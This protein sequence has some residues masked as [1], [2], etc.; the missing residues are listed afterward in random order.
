M[1][2]KLWPK[3]CF[4]MKTW[5]W[6]GKLGKLCF[7]KIQNVFP[8]K[9]FGTF[10]DWAN[11]IIHRFQYCSIIWFRPGIQNSE[12][13]WSFQCW[14]SDWPCGYF[15]L[16]TFPLE[17]RGWQG[18]F[19]W[20]PKCLQT[21]QQVSLFVR[22]RRWDFSIWERSYSFVWDQLAETDTFTQLNNIF[23]CYIF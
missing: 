13:I 8:C 18:S 3:W 5:D 11:F 6:V 16:R 4:Q 21:P 12:F 20:W 14:R 2:E 7:Y 23:A 22:R 1:G 9:S 19:R 17:E 15:V 10:Q